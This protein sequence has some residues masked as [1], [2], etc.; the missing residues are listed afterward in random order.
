[1]TYSNPQAYDRFMG[2]WSALLA[3]AFIR[4][5]GIRDGQRV[6]D[7]GSG[8]GSL[9]RGL[10]LSRPRICVVGIEPVADYVCFAREVVGDAR[11]E[12]RVGAAEAL[13]FPPETFDAA[14]GLLI[15]QDLND[16]IRAV[17]GLRAGPG[18][19]RLA[20]GIFEGLPM[21]SL[22]WKAAE[23]VAP[24]VIK[25]RE[26]GNPP[27]DSMGPSELTKLWAAAGLSDIRMATLE[28]AMEFRSFDD[29]WLPFLGGATPTS[30]FAAS[31]NMETGG[32]LAGTLRDMMPDVRPDGSFVLPA[33]AWAVAGIAG[34]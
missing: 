1:V 34:R 33:V 14:L 20:S 22:F 18:P 29:Y 3:P 12:F 5:A 21:L 26:A 28:L 16:P 13:A 7:V 4:F 8:T 11:V 25:A 17:R 2:R 6:L 15:V 32:A 31:L 27:S 19:W 9:S 23:K 30:A 10:L 24:E